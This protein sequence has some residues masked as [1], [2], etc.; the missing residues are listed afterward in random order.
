M[1][2][3]LIPSM[4]NR[5]LLLLAV[6]ALLV[7]GAIVLQLVRL[8]VAQGET[9]RGRAE[10]VLTAQRL[11]PTARGAI[12][13]R[14]L[15]LLAID[16]P[17]H[18]IAVMYDVISGDWARSQ[19]TAEARRNNRYRWSELGREDRERLCLQF[20]PRYDAMI[21]RLWA[22]LCA[23]SS[24]ERA[25][26]DERRNEVIRR[27]EQIASDV[28]ARQAE[29]R[30]RE[31][32][33]TGEASTAR[34]RPI[35]EHRSA[36]ALLI[37]VSEETLLQV[38]RLTADAQAQARLRKENP[39]APQPEPEDDLRI[40]DSVAIAASRQRVYP[41]ETLTLEVDLST[42]PGALKQDK[43]QEITVEGVAWSIIGDLRPVWREDVESRPY[44][45]SG[46]DGEKAIDLGGY[47]PGDRTG[48]W[49]IE[50]AFE[51][52]LRG[53]RGRIIEYVDDSHEE[54]RTD[55][56]TGASVRLALDIRLQA[57]VQALLDPRLGLTRVQ[58]WHAK[59]YSA[60]SANVQEGED[61]R[62]DPLKP[63]LGDTLNAAAVIIE[64]TSGDIL[65]AVSMP[66][67]G[68]KQ[69]RENPDAIW[70]DTIHRPFVNRAIS[71]PYQPGSTVKPVVL[72]AAITA[73]ELVPDGTISCTG[74]LYSDQPDR[75][76]CWIYKHYN[77][78]THDIV[79]KH[80]PGGADAISRSCNIFFY[81]L[82][83]RMGPLR[84]VDWYGRFGLG[85]KLDCG[86]PEE[87][88]GRLPSIGG[89]R[90]GGGGVTTGLAPQDAVMMGIGQGRVEWTVLQAA[91]AYATIARS[92]RSLS[93]TLVQEVDGQP[94]RARRAE[95]LHI[96]PQAI[97]VAMQGLYD[98]VN[99]FH[100]TAHHLSLLEN[101]PVTFSFAPANPTVKIFGKSGTATA[102][103]LRE[104]IDDDGDG[105]PDRYGPPLRAG[106]HAWFV[107]FVQKPGSSRPDYAF[108]VIVEYGGSGGA[109]AGPI[110][111]QIL[112]ALRAEG[113]L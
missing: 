10:H 102:P 49:G 34:R 89:P 37:N 77:G 11:V 90:G 105:K 95:D 101:Q 30:A 21:E 46:P 15:R 20:Q 3:R 50:S 14:S 106:D 53:K 54:E 39:A 28:Y 71:Q 80:A 61:H 62:E 25:V 26:L 27:V 58:P 42:F 22:T 76:R 113:Y 73:G 91:N 67:V 31:L 94:H 98:A 51:E 5:R 45:T 64:V 83:Q 99:K 23:A 84:L 56:V 41:L 65:A 69:M 109:V 43:K 81:T 48:R 103:P 79:I 88:R 40:W 8:T 63:K 66:T 85:E 7:L 13:D 12:Y 112:Y 6:V 108:A 18:D 74:H 59:E 86:L 24:I 96:H 35:S 111:N 47:L 52:A 97:E 87:S 110:A 16:K 1:F 55:P 104:P 75:Y 92:G 9:W 32:E 78:I 29:R 2:H 93:P 44:S 107:G 36:H 68:M 38:R 17:S 57:R 60:Q 19:A 100:G 4:F 82:G 70:K 33:E 72:V